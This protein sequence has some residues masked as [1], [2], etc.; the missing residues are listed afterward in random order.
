MPHSA[1][2]SEIPENRTLHVA[3]KRRTSSSTCAVTSFSER[4]RSP[5]HVDRNPSDGL[6]G[7]RHTKD[8]ADQTECVE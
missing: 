7:D 3:L 6:H 8:G 5:K 2:A 1:S 4:G